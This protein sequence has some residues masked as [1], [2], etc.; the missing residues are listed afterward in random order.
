[1]RRPLRRQ[2]RFSISIFEG[3]SPWELGPP[4]DRSRPHLTVNDVSDLVAEL[5]ADP[6]MVRHRGTWHLFFEALD[7]H[8]RKGVICLATSDEPLGSWTYRGTVLRE[9]FHLSYPYVFEW[10]GQHYMIPETGEA[11]SVR[12]YRADAFP[13]RWTLAATLLRGD[14]LDP[15]PFQFDGRWWMF[16]SVHETSVH[17]F[18]AEALE[19]P[20]V[21]HPLSPLIKGDASRVRPGG[22]VVVQDGKPIRLAQDCSEYYG[23][24]LRAFMVEEL[25]TSTYRERECP[26][27]PI[28]APDGDGWRS[29]AMHHAD[30]HQLAPDHWI[31]CVDGAAKPLVWGFEGAPR[32]STRQLLAWLS[33]RESKRR[34][35]APAA[36]APTA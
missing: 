4:G 18:S 13:A 1:M 23:R 3:A 21:E 22:R 10:Q 33:G 8:T 15:S 2:T 36:W 9:P 16:A 11:S 12:L 19:G 25:T 32:R 24:Q 7:T 35:T 20:W 28:L 27:S 14:Y 31:A 29:V 6:F 17:L 5:V 30:L 26:Q 34:I